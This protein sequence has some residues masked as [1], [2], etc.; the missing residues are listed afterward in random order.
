MNNLL[1]NAIKYSPEDSHIV[2]YVDYKEN[3]KN[4]KYVKTMVKDEGMGIDDEFH[5]ILYDAFSTTPNKPTNNESK[6]GLGLAIVKKIVELH[7]GKVGFNSV[8]GSG[9]EF[10]F[11]IPISQNS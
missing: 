11:C 3:E 9:S 1:N 7:H 2:V 8:K 4:E 6:T 10:Y 5:D